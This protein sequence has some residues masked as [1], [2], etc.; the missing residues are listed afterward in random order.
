MRALTLSA[1]LALTACRGC[2]EA[3]PATLAE[4]EDQLLTD[5]RRAVAQGCLSETAT[6]A[7]LNV[8]A[9]GA[10]L[11]GEAEGCGDTVEVEAFT[12]CDGGAPNLQFQPDGELCGASGPLRFEVE[13]A[14]A[15]GIVVG[16]YTYDSLFSISLGFITRVEPGRPLILAEG[17]VYALREGN[18]GP[19]RD[20]EPEEMQGRTRDL[21]QGGTTSTEA[22]N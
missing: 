5:A 15:A 9:Q 16:I 4:D 13:C 17:A 10:W 3:D 20:F 12:S 6:A 8:G 14:T 21:I 2:R 19:W 1:L 22:C 11:R 7:L 18:A